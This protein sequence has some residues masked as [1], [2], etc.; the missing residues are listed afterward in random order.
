MVMLN[1]SNI[2]ATTKEYEYSCEKV[3]GKPTEK[4]KKI[5]G[6]ESRPGSRES[7]HSSVRA[8]SRKMGLSLY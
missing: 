6:S 1:I 8:E 5:C 2:T 3:M 4:N 7:K